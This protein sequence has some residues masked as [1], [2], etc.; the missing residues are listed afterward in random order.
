MFAIY[1]S[2]IETAE[3]LFAAVAT[4]LR[5]PAYF[6]KNWDA[7]DECL[8]DMDRLPSKGYVLLFREAGPFWQRASRVAGVF[9]ESWLF[10][11]EEWSRHGVP[12]HVIFLW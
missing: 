8:R 4:E 1:G 10:A 12:F 11:A 2:S 9:V 3:H 5:F 7:L 6:G